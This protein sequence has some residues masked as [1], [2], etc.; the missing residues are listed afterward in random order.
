MLAYRHLFHA[1]SAADVFKHALLVQLLIAAARKDKPYF[2]LET[3][4]GIGRYDLNHPW[5]QKNAEFQEGILRLWGR[6]DAPESLSVYLEVVRSENSGRAL[7]YYPGSPL[8]ASRLLRERDRMVLAE[9]NREDC[10]QLAGLLARD[11]RVRVHHMDGYQALKAF[12]PPP[13]R[14]GLILIDSSFDRAREFARLAEALVLAH[15]RFATGVY[16]VWYPLMEPA[17]VRAFERDVVASGIRRILRLELSVR[18][19]QWR[20]EM[21]GSRMLVVNPPFEFDGISGA[22]LAWLWK[23]LSPEGEGRHGVDWLVGE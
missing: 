20:G 9:L 4:A 8:I 23:A 7:R 13:E 5:A 22:M 16:A 2:Y 6:T 10:A 17:A 18:P 21:R 15:G 11:R 14:R 12:L 19:E 1:G 3:H